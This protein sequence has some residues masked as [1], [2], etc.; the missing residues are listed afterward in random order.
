MIAARWIK[1]RFGPGTSTAGSDNA[2]GGKRTGGDAA[3]RSR[4]DTKAVKATDFNS[5]LLA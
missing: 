3:F 4:R 2:S 5:D 1:G